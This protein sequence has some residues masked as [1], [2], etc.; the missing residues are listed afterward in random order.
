MP[1]PLLAFAL[2]AAGCIDATG[3]HT[4][5]R[6]PQHARVAV[7]LEGKPG[8]VVTWNELAYDI[9]YAEDQFRTFK[10]QRAL[11]MM[12]LAMHDALNSIEAKYDRYAYRGPRRD[13]DP[14]L[15]AA[16]SAY[17]VLV[18][19]YPAATLRLDSVLANQRSVTPANALGAAAIELGLAAADAVL[20]MRQ[21]DGWNH[22]GTY[23]FTTGTGHYATTPDWQGF[24][25]QPGFSEATPFALRAPNAFRPPPPPPLQSIAYAR[26]Y[27]EVKNYGA[28]NSAVRTTDQTAYAIWWLEFAEGSIN[29][30]TR[31]LVIERSVGLW[32]AARLFA[33]LHMALYDGYIAT[34]DA[35][36]TYRHWRPFTAI[37]WPD[38][39]NAATQADANWQSL[40]PAPPFPE[41][42]SAHATACAASFTVLSALWKGAPFSMTTI[43]APPEMPERSFVSFRAAAEECAD[44]RVRLG[45][46]FR[47]A[48]DEGLRLGERVANHVLQTQLRARS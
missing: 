6:P 26:A 39:G 37:R 35:K 24:V 5:E 27:D 9:A 18:S 19:L 1:Y 25:L 2:L 36:F 17:A 23:A 20:R 48:T 33:Q 8:V 42:V 10:G 13:A 3:E 30:L 41:Y 11:A 21:N 28:L 46:H 44:S 4:V 29:R 22:P 15:A 16:Q 38:D 14:K 47:Y 40:Q 34:W 45:W 7:D 12:N 43:T 31:R 32:P